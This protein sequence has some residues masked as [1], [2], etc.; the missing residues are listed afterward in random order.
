MIDAA[1]VFDVD[2]VLLELTAN[3]ES[4]FFA[5]FT[6][7]CDPHLL[8]RDWNSYLIRN[9]DDI[10]DEIMANHGIAAELKP[11]I[12]DDYVRALAAALSSGQLDASAISGA[13]DLLAA[14]NGTVHIG[15]ATANFREAARLRL[16]LVNLWSAV[17]GHACG[18]EGGGHKHAILARTLAGLPVPPQRVVYV[19]DNVQDVEAGRRNGVHFIGFS[20]SPE[21]RATL[22]TAGAAITCG[23]HSDTLRH[24]RRFLGA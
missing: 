16:Q 12:V 17:S 19:G 18:A 7:Y 14:L 21:R 8:S 15:I 22:Q 9:D 20:Q 13:A 6:P 3:E 11:Q 1:V 5:A 2:G 4:L 23:N 24:I 10:V